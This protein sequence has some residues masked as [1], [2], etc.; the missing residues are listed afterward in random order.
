MNATG[1]VEPNDP[2]VEL[3]SRLPDKRL[4]YSIKEVA[5]MTGLSQRTV[6]RRIA[7]G[8]LPVVRSQGRTLIPKQIN[9]EAGGVGGT[10]LSEA[11][12]RGKLRT[13][14]GRVS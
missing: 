10:K 4:T 11:I 5:G 1:G 9:Q 3:L 6:L 7:D 13:R 14:K 2:I 8:S 12:K